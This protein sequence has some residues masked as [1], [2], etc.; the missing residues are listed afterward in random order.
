MR[1]YSLISTHTHTHTHTKHAQAHTHIY[2]QT[3]A[4]THTRTHINTYLRARYAV[5]AAVVCFLGRT[6]PLLVPRTQGAGVLCVYECTVCI[7]ELEKI[8]TVQ[9]HT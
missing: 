8:H 6:A 4:N 3:H 5:P 9:I 1:T 2:T 7:Y